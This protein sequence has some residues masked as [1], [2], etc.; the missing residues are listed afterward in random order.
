MGWMLRNINQVKWVEWSG[1]SSIQEGSLDK[2]A[3]TRR[4]SKLEE[5]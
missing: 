3:E 1:K 4:S 5:W 2:C